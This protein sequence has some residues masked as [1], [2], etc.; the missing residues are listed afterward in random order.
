MC[1]LS[2]EKVTLNKVDHYTPKAIGQQD[3][4]KQVIIC[5]NFTIHWTLKNH[6]AGIDDF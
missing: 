2:T 1:E 3:R 5:T 6:L 4:Y